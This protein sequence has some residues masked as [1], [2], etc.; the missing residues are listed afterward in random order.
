MDTKKAYLAII[1]G[2]TMVLIGI[3]LVN[4]RVQSSAATLL[5][6]NLLDCQTP[7]C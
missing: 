2:G 4:Q 7:L 5:T 6:R 1:A 3:Y